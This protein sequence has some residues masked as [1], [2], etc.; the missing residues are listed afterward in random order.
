VAR[1]PEAALA[2]VSAPAVLADAGRDVDW[3]LAVLR[4]LGALAW[5]LPG[6]GDLHARLRLPASEAVAEL[7]ARVRVDVDASRA[8]HASHKP[9]LLP[10]FF[11]V[12]ADRRIVDESQH[13]ASLALFGEQLRL[14]GGEAL[15]HFDAM[16][17][18]CP[19]L[20][21][22]LAQRLLEEVPLAQRELRDL[23]PARVEAIATRLRAEA[24]RTGIVGLVAAGGA[25]SAVSGIA[26]IG[27][28]PGGTGGFSGLALWGLYGLETRQYEKQVRAKVGRAVVDLGI[29]RACARQ[30]LDENR[31]RA[32]RLARFSYHMKQDKALLL[33]GMAAA[34]TA[35]AT[36]STDAP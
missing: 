11:E 30:W 35:P 5:R 15:A 22:P 16:V 8:F 13:G 23:A 12:L 36:P 24:R 25:L 32:L 18:R 4:A 28:G 9:I 21:E 3:A 26:L 19:E 6:I 14:D 1:E 29:T 34:A 20:V 27:G 17:A 7:S 33:L 31:W 2:M 10:G